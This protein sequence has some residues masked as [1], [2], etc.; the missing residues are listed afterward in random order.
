MT[1]RHREKVTSLKKG[2][3]ADDR[4]VFAEESTNTS[5]SKPDALG[6]GL[7]TQNH[8]YIHTV[9]EF[10]DGGASAEFELWGYYAMAD[11]WA[12]L[13]DYGALTQAAA[14]KHVKVT[15]TRGADRVF[16]KMTNVA[17]MTTGVNAWIGG[18]TF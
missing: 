10:L 2:T 1:Q 9:I 11:R 4:R 13:D 16:L 8:R 7:A 6:D 15:E 5:A 17:G 12:L 14:A 18:S 3:D